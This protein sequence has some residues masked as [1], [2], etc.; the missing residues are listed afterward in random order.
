MEKN[1]S[2]AEVMEQFEKLGG[3][4]IQNNYVNYLKGFDL[5]DLHRS[6]ENL[7][8]GEMRKMASG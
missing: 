5:D 6:V 1:Y 7:S 8:G 2:N 3:W 4:E